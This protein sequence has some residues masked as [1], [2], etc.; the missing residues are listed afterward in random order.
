[1]NRK[2]VIVAIVIFVV[3]LSIVGAFVAVLKL[4]DKKISPNAINIDTGATETTDVEPALGQTLN[5]TVMPGDNISKVANYFYWDPT[6]YME[7][8]RSNNLLAPYNLTPG[9]VLVIDQPMRRRRTYTVVFGDVLSALAESFYGN[10]NLGS[11]IEY[12][13]NLVAPYTLKPGLVLQYFT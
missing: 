3:I 2:R 5:Y 11:F 1:M 6:R 12:S 7:V 8:V 9:Q 13:N 10:A 4:Q